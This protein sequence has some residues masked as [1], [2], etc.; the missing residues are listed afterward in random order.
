MPRKICPCGRWSV[1]PNFEDFRAYPSL[2]QHVTSEGL[3]SI[4]VM[5]AGQLAAFA[6]ASPNHCWLSCKALVL[7]FA[8]GSLVRTRQRRVTGG[9]TCDAYA[10]HALSGDL[11]PAHAVAGP[12]SLVLD[13]LGGVALRCFPSSGQGHFV[14]IIEPPAEAQPLLS[15]GFGV[16]CPD[17]RSCARNHLE[18]AAI[19]GASACLRR[20][21]SSGSA[22][23]EFSFELEVFLGQ[24]VMPFF[25]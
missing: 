4:R 9:P 15:R 12:L 19:S 5:K 7:A 25:Q 11:Y 3:R 13:S 22:C 18:R 21:S 14:G 2:N 10:G 23:L 24:C 16:V 1:T 20:S 8:G 6:F 17:C